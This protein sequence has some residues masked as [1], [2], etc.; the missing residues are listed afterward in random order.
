MIE[1]AGSGCG[2]YFNDDTLISHSIKVPS[3][4]PETKV[5]PFQDIAVGDR[6]AN[7]KRK[8]ELYMYTSDVC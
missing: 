1:W 4:S 2:L 7:W 6:K 3:E 5:S 8:K